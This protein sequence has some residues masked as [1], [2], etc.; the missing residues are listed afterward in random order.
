MPSHA[1]DAEAFPGAA[2]LST[3]KKKKNIQKLYI[4]KSDRRVQSQNKQ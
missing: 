2:R 1:S 3:Q 4:R